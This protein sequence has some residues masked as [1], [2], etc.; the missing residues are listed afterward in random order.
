MIS[1][2]AHMTKTDEFLYSVDAL[3]DK[4]S[5][6]YLWVERL[7]YDD[8]A[9]A[10]VL[11]MITIWKRRFVGKCAVKCRKCLMSNL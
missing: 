2:T 8:I 11:V 4:M 3:E 5:A 9:A 10:I 6:Q 7:C 1:N